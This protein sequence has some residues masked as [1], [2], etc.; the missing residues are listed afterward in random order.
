MLVEYESTSEYV[1]MGLINLHYL[2]L[3]GT[4]V[5]DEGLEYLSSYRHNRI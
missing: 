5:T 3:S 4:Q 1:L 2:C